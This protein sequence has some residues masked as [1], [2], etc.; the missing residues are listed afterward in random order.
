LV[1]PYRYKI[2]Y[3]GRG[4]AKSWSFA[5]A[6]VGEA[7]RRPL[8]ILCTR[9]FQNS[10]ADS[11]HR[12]ITD[13]ISALDLDA[14]FTITQTSIK[15]HCGSEFIFKG[16]QRS[17]QE[18]KSTEGVDICWVEEAQTISEDSWEILIP[19]IRKEGS[20]I[21]ISFNPQ[22]DTD[23]TFR[24]FVLNTPPDSILQKVNWS[25]NPNFPEVLNREREYMLRTDPDAYQ[26]VWE[27]FCRQ[28]S[29]AIV[30]RGRFVVETFDAPPSDARLYYGLDFGFSQDPM[31]LVRCWMRDNVLYVDHES[32]G[33]G[34]E[35][36]DIAEFINRVPG[37]DTWPI[38]GDS[39]RP[40]TI[41]HARRRGFDM[42]AA[43]KWNGSVEDGIAV[44]KGFEKIIIHQRCKHTAEEFR[45]YSYEVDRQTNDIL[46]KICD[47][48]NHCID[49][50]RYALDGFIKRPN[51]FDNIDM[52][53]YPDE[54]AEA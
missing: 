19:T 16:L 6:L 31:A 25:Q 40:E 9:E 34:V 52:P 45:L 43:K 29:D 13:Q 3:G 10:I 46:P 39:S 22:Q 37:A 32:Y 54:L 28:I 21:W 49:A 8:R 11:V 18:I 17:I 5:R 20:E 33:I 7:Y 26:H 24:R 51:F 15:S 44:M 12:L 23:P 42:A 35:L 1:N 36:D 4:G 50:I 53:A 41:S 48:H 30:F 2:Y 47:K 38:R 14:W 27:G